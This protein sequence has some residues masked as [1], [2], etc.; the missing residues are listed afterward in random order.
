[1]ASATPQ[2]ARWLFG[3]SLDL[4]LGAGLI[5]GVVFIALAVAGGP[6]SAALPMGV[7]PLLLLVSQVP[8]LGA[9]LVR[10]YENGASRR[11]YALF[12]IWATVAL[13][14][15][16][17]VGV[18]H[19]T[20]GALLVTLYMTVTPWH[21]T[22]QN[23]GIALV[24]FGRA[25]VVLEPRT[26]R[27][28]YASFIL[29]CLLF[30]ISLHSA[31]G[32]V[33]Y[34]PVTTDG[35]IYP[36]YS[37]GIPLAVRDVSLL[38]G[39]VVWLW[40]TGEAILRLREH[41]S[42]RDLG[43]G[44]ALFGTQALWFL[45]PVLAMFFAP[46]GRLHPLGPDA[47][48][49]TFLWILIAHSIQYLWIT[50]Y[51]ARRE[52]PERTLRSFLLQSWLAG[53]AAIALPVVIF[54]PGLLGRVPYDA[55]LALLVGSVVSLH[56]ILL[57]SAIWKLRDGRI[58]R[59]LL[60]GGGGTSEER[61]VAPRRVLLRPIWLAA[62]AA[63][64]L[65]LGAGG[66]AEHR[67]WRQLE[68]GEVAGAERSVALLAALGRESARARATLGY[69]KGERGDLS[70]ARGELERSLELHPTANSWLN[71]GLLF[72]HEGAAREALAAFEKSLLLA[73]EDAQTLHAA[74]RAALAAGL[75]ERAEAHLERAAVLAPSDPA[76]R[77]TL[78]R[79]RAPVRAGGRS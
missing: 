77:R 73:P 48:P 53:A 52:Q 69:L 4:V 23:Y 15:L 63:G 43:P 10:V 44:L 38:V 61:A 79:A 74:G 24:F 13:V 54:A 56:H 16:F 62:G 47:Q 60:S 59:I 12:A 2:N 33:E 46:L 78:E 22:G 75:T 67:L 35:T 40:V 3:P 11:R 65:V 42:W 34:S 5:Y 8:H 6:M 37:L 30:L 26:K 29:S 41:A 25:G 64:V 27:F 14:A 70:G 55:G 18:Y 31:R 39:V 20:L 21:F 32:P 7:M 50:A 49:Y 45:L 1:M 17:G 19:A 72:E 51:Y 28:V 68:R 36:F 66:L 76:I 71:L 57:D 58:S 9:T